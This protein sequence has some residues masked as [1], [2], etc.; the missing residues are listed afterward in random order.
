MIAAGLQV[1]WAQSG[2]EFPADEKTGVS[3]GTFLGPNESHDLDYE[4][5]L[6]NKT[7]VMISVGTF[8][9]LARK[10][11]GRF[12]ELVMVDI[13][14]EISHFNR[15][16]LQ[17]ILDSENSYDYLSRLL[18]KTPVA[19][20]HDQYLR[21]EITAETLLANLLA[22]PSLAVSRQTPVGLQIQEILKKPHTDDGTIYENLVSS[23]TK[24]AK[25]PSW[26]THVFS[27]DEVHRL[28]QR[29]INAGK[30]KVLTANLASPKV[31]AKLGAHY[32]SRNL[33]VTVIDKSNVFYYLESR[34]AY[35]GFVNAMRALPLAK[36][37]LLLMVANESQWT[38]RRWFA[39]DMSPEMTK[40]FE[41]HVNE[42]AYLSF[43]AQEFLQLVD[44]RGIEGSHLFRD[45][46]E[47]LVIAETHRVNSC[48]RLFH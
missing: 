25:S 6:R 23:F 20:D 29:D 9:S 12:D 41:R 32:R 24:L 48:A 11:M 28:T 1:A 17:L 44:E 38:H 19:H 37:T 42:W 33:E 45:L 22:S 31:F 27:S 39:K 26:R 21:G 2:A 34:E 46:I 10:Q 4:P 16:N 36:E 15:L 14:E 18:A 5:V 13:D 8:R 30:I 3:E 7:G 47:D 40:R 35:T 43:P